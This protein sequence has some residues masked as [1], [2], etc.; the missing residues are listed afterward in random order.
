MQGLFRPL[1]ELRGIILAHTGRGHSRVKAYAMLTKGEVGV[2]KSKYVRKNIPFCTYFVI[3]S[4]ARYF[5][6]T[7]LFLALIFITVL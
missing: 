5:Y 2:D 7:L 6:H 4:Y 1:W 3:F